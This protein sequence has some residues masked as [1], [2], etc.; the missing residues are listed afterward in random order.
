M[1]NEKKNDRATKVVQG[2]GGGAIMPVSMA[3]VYRIV[4]REKIGLALGVWGMAA[5][6]GPAVGPTLGGYIVDHLNWRFIFTM[7]IPIGVTGLILMPAAIVTTLMMPVSGFLFDRFGPKVLAVAGL[8]L[9]AWGTL[10]FHNL[11]LNKQS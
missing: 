7:D 1:F 6:C 3:I 4:P 5:V 11:S 9:T 10:E 8:T 2:I